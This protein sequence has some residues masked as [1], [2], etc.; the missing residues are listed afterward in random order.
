MNLIITHWDETQSTI[1]VTESQ[2]IDLVAIAKLWYQTD[3]IQ[4]WELKEAE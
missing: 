2:K 4:A 3:A 1:T